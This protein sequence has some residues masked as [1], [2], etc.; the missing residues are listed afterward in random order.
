MEVTLIEDV[1]VGSDDNIILGLFVGLALGPVVGITV[2]GVDIAVGA[3]DDCIDGEAVR[4]D[5]LTVGID[6]G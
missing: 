4:F 6:D 2:G 1:I 5:G 3:S